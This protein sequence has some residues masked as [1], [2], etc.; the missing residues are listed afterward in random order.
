MIY[1]RWF[2]VILLAIQCIKISAQT[3]TYEIDY[4]QNILSK[5]PNDLHASYKLTEALVFQGYKAE[6]DTEKKVWFDR[7]RFIS[8]NC[9]SIYPK[10]WQSNYINALVYGA[11]QQISTDPGF[12]KECAYKVKM[13]ID[14]SIKLN[15]DHAASWS[16]LGLWHYKLAS[17]NGFHAVF[18]KNLK[19]NASFKDAQIHL[20]KA[21]E[22]SPDEPRYYA[23]LAKV[24][25]EL[26]MPINAES[27]LSRA[28]TICRG[29]MNK[30]AF[31][32]QKCN[33]LL[34]QIKNK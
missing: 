13:W 21:I 15:P 17:A 22:L 23:M 14:E 10:T 19:Q 11:L 27:Q 3:L 5:Q 7:A 4:Y 16:V 24:Y 6:S 25:L 32:F 8:D 33:E 26:H 18:L 34:N 20:N 12:R 29:N 9:Y 28:I 31:V 30:Y 1:P 2:I